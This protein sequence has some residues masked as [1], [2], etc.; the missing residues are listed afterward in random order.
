MNDLET[1]SFEN[2]QKLA[3][4]TAKAM[5]S[6]NDDLHHAALGMAGEAGEFADAVKKFTVYNKPLD[7]SNAIEELGDLLW[8]I[9][10]A[11]NSLATTVED[12]AR[13]N[14]VKLKVRYPDKYT[15]E[16]AVVR[17]DKVE[18]TPMAIHWDKL[19]VNDN[20]H[21]VAIVSGVTYRTPLDS[22]DRP[23]PI[24]DV[25]I[26]IETLSLSDN[27]VILQIG[28]CG[29]FQQSAICDDVATHLNIYVSNTDQ[30]SHRDVSESTMEFWGKQDPELYHRVRSGTT[31][32]PTALAMLTEFIDKLPVPVYMVRFVSKGDF[33]FRVLEHAY[34]EAGLPVPWKYWQLC[35]LRSLTSTFHWVKQVTPV[36]A[37][38]AHSDAVA[39]LDTLSVINKLVAMLPREG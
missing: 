9:A 1:M 13:A 10:L 39:Q 20:N 31:L 34:N 28:A 6:Y 4:R 16:L 2:Y 38:D 27:A 14:I 30:V 36:V 26:D 8:Y 17:L 18:S 12:I 7:I 37:H 3:M 24:Y 21:Y 25:M 35:N 33:D 29:K 5:P 23:I 15:D 11:A 32:L 19:P 22:K